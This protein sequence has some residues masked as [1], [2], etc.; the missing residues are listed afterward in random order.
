MS[1]KNIMSRPGCPLFN[2]STY[3][4]AANRSIR[5]KCC[6]RPAEDRER[7]DHTQDDNGLT[8]TRKPEES[9]T[10]NGPKLW[11]LE[12][13][14]ALTAE[15]KRGEYFSLDDEVKDKLEPLPPT[16]ARRINPTGSSNSRPKD[17]LLYTSPSPRD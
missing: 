9:S 6:D 16:I 17:C 3:I 12:E 13:A 11:V 8:W 5:R 7:V 14:L 4:L 2:K 10:E 1:L 15:Q